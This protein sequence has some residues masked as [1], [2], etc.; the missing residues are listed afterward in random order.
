MSHNGV[1]AVHI[2]FLPDGLEKFLGG[3]HLPPVLAEIPENVELDGGQCEIHA[4]QGT[5]MA[6][7]A[8]IKAPEIMFVS[9][10]TVLGVVPSVPSKLG[11]DS[12]HQFQG[13]KWLGDII[14]CSQ[15]QT[16]D[17]IGIVYFGTKHED[18]KIMVL[19]DFLA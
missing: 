14:V 7:L 9:L 12:G 18:G 1:V 6:V 8:D 4:V 5:L 11:L 3:N 2:L 19:S 10:L 15:S 17:L 16:H 13:T